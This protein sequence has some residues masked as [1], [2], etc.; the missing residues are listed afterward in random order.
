MPLII[1]ADNLNILNPMVAQAL[2]PSTPSPSRN[3][4][5]GSSRPAPT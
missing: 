4:P 3:W 2:T 1:A 5:A